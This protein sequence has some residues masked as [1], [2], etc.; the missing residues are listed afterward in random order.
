MTVGE[1]MKR[2]REE[3]GLSQ[4]ALAAITGISPTSL[5]QYENDAYLPRIDAVE[6]LADTLGLSIDEYVG[7]GTVGRFTPDA[8]A[9][10]KA[11]QH[12]KNAAVKNFARKLS[13]LID[14]A[15]REETAGGMNE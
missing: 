11:Q 12:I 7:H 3:A 4:A 13:K 6:M 2:A 8:T 9:V 10:K 1:A 14:D 5:S 15:V